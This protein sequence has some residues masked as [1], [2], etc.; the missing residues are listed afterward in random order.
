[1]KEQA[2]Q[3]AKPA[4]SCDMVN[5]IYMELQHR[6]LPLDLAQWQK[7]YLDNMYKA[8]IEDGKRLRMFHHA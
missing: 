6:E 2:H 5:R 7:D 4:S 3:K 8:V 1:M